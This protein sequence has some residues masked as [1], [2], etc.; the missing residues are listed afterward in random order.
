MSKLKAFYVFLFIGFLAY[1]LFYLSNSDTIKNIQR[2]LEQQYSL[3]RQMPGV[4]LV[5]HSSGRK[6]EIVL[7]HGE[8][9]TR[10]DSSEILKYYDSEFKRL[11]WQ[12]VGQERNKPFG[13]DN[14]EDHHYFKKGD[15]RA[16]VE[17]SNATSSYG[18]TFAVD[19]AWEW[20]D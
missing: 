6:P 18:W 17:C 2:E 10:A 19:L 9:I 1:Y 16:T 8:F 14:V 7:V 12:L 5:G 3:I 13:Y 11:G 15:Y 4:T 20:Y